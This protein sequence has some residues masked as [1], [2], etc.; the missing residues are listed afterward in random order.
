MKVSTKTR[1]SFYVDLSSQDIIKLTIRLKHLSSHLP[2]WNDLQ[3]SKSFLIHQQHAASPMQELNFWVEPNS[4]LGNRSFALY[5]DSLSRSGE[6]VAV[7]PSGSSE[8][9]LSYQFDWYGCLT[10]CPHLERKRH[11]MPVV[12]IL[13][14]RQQNPSIYLFWI[15]LIF[16][17]PDFSNLHS[18]QKHFYLDIEKKLN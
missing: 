16:K 2:S 3:R 12:E 9:V 15:Y 1:T 7:D 18:A 10:G 5:G 13:C 4:E 14:K 6:Y 11:K 8:V 17:T